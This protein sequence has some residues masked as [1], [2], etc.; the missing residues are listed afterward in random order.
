ML[1]LNVNV[2]FSV[3]V[4][5]QNFNFF[6][7]EHFLPLYVESKFTPQKNQKT[8]GRDVIRFYVVA[9]HHQLLLLIKRG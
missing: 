5:F 7:Q 1:I 3:T 2:T 6:S 9:L 8:R 4:F